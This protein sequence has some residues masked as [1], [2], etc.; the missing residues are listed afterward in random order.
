M[1]NNKKNSHTRKK[2]NMRENK[3]IV[4]TICYNLNLTMR[5]NDLSWIL[6]CDND[7]KLK[8][9]KNYVKHFVETIARI[10]IASNACYKKQDTFNTSK[11]FKNAT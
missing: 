4:D 9:V 10:N 5:N 8:N 1:K 7:Y 11:K 6:L 3:L 2:Y